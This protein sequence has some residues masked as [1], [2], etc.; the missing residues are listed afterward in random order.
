L[1][2]EQMNVIGVHDYH[3]RYSGEFL[4]NKGRRRCTAVFTAY[5]SGKRTE[6]FFYHKLLSFLWK[7]VI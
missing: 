7:V 2:D 3:A 1:N 5:L 6:Q 4:K